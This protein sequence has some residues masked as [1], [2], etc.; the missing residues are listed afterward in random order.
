[1]RVSDCFLPPRIELW[2]HAFE[3][4]GGLGNQRLSTT[5]EVGASSDLRRL[6]GLYAGLRDHKSTHEDTTAMSSPLRSQEST[7][8]SRVSCEVID[9]ADVS[10]MHDMS[11][12]F[13]TQISLPLATKHRRRPLTPT[14]PRRDSKITPNQITSMRD[15]SSLPV[16]SNSVQASIDDMENPANSVEPTTNLLI[17]KVTSDASIKEQQA[18]SRSCANPTK[19]APSRT[20]SMTEKRD[21]WPGG[22]TLLTNRGYLP[23][24]ITKLSKDQQQVLETGN[25]W[26]PSKV[27]R[28][29]RGSLP[30]PILKVF[31]EPADKVPDEA[32]AQHGMKDEG[33][34]I[35]EQGPEGIQLDEV[36]DS[37][38]NSLDRES[39]GSSS[40]VST[41]ASWSPTPRSPAILQPA[42]PDNSPLQAPYRRN[43]SPVPR[44]EGSNASLRD[45]IHRD[46]IVE[47][48]SPVSSQGGKSVVEA[49][50]ISMDADPAAV[51]K[52]I[53]HSS[54]ETSDTTE[55]KGKKRGSGPM[56]SL[57]ISLSQDG[58]Q[59]QVQAIESS[60]P[61]LPHSE[62]D[63]FSQRDPT[64][65]APQTQEK[66]NH[67]TIGDKAHIHV[68]RTP[69]APQTSRFIGGQDASDHQAISS[70][71]NADGLV[72]NDQ[73]PRSSTSVVA[74]TCMYTQADTVKRSIIGSRLCLHGGYE[75][76]RDE[77]MEVEVT[78]DIVPISKAGDCQR[79][80]FDTPSSRAN[81]S[82]SLPE[83]RLSCSRLG[84]RKYS[85]DGHGTP[86]TELPASEDGRQPH[87]SPA[88]SKK[89]RRMS[90]FP[91]L[92]ALRDLSSARTPSEMARESRREFFRNQLKAVSGKTPILEETEKRTP[93]HDAYTKDCEVSRSTQR[94]DTTPSTDLACR[95]GT[96]PRSG[97]DRASCLSLR[98]ES[99]YKSYKATYPGYQGDALHFH[100]ACKQIKALHQEGKAPHPSLWDDFIF[101]R[102]HD[103]RDYLALVTEACD[104]ALPY[105]QYYNEHVDKPS[106]MQLV[107]KASYIL[108]LETN[109]TLGSSVKSPSLAVQIHDKA[110]KSLEDSVAVDSS[111]SNVEPAQHMDSP[112]VVRTD[113]KRQDLNYKLDS[114]NRDETEPTQ[115]SSVKVKQWVEEQL[116][117]K[118][119]RMGSPE[120][121][122]PVVATEQG[123]ITQQNINDAAEVPVSSSLVHQPAALEHKEKKSD[124]CDDRDT[125]FKTFART[126][127][128][129][130]SERKQLK[131]SVEIGAKGCLEPKLQN[132]IDIFTL[133]KK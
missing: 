86:G 97:V 22:R 29:I 32:S 65:A 30:N 52:E 4:V 19:Q 108:S 109:S 51:A 74:G 88:S 128:T 132:V 123:S 96:R 93:F 70:Y 18:I 100:K 84:K 73:E 23:R 104:D 31:T 118:T 114:Y 68:H 48:R 106:R 43:K 40:S 41:R 105:I 127:A 99:M 77:Q 36:R 75:S 55:S 101:R 7:S 42:F 89:P 1:M 33:A 115:A 95:K 103:Y 125:P 116:M 3:I 14:Q 25:A 11:Q 81:P 10:E 37:D 83:E 58:D 112:I 8:S 130:V 71:K 94:P 15:T 20:P 91:S 92:E 63:R 46:Q 57:E 87:L 12:P 98:G 67:Q 56:V 111:A 69:F 66:L 129:L 5:V 26:Q 133:Y 54:Q 80:T 78:H 21:H 24:Y 27:D 64:I 107:V 17:A 13:Q 39:D 53:L 72:A 120:L 61:L 59:G 76:S 124:W 2:V 34:M 45:V 44:C 6:L 62:A 131:G 79:A 90:R 117:E 122:S 47:S 126:Y 119:M 121:G 82:L 50:E 35:A 102:H 9:D 113:H 28:Q 16:A 38:R 49:T 110:A 85:H 60:R